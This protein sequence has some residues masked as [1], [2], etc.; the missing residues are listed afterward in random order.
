MMDEDSPLH[1]WSLACSRYIA[2]VHWM[3]ASP[4]TP[5]LSC[6]LICFPVFLLYLILLGLDPYIIVPEPPSHLC[7]AP[8]RHQ[9]CQE[10]ELGAQGTRFRGA[11]LILLFPLCYFSSVLLQSWVRSYE[12][13]TSRSSLRLWAPCS[14]PLTHTHAHVHHTHA[15]TAV[16]TPMR[17]MHVPCVHPYTYAV[18]TCIAWTRRH[19]THV[20]AYI[21][22]AYSSCV[23]TCTHTCHI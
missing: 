23:C 17:V 18:H 7:G 9:N 14:M 16:C 2:N 19:Y 6:A 10:T 11:M 5:S 22:C 15:H 21:T 13:L 8:L 1:P 3:I 20:H 4:S 12:R